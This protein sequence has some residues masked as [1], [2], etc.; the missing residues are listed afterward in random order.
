M[1]L[2]LVVQ[3]VSVRLVPALAVFS[4]IAFVVITLLT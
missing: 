2:R 4:V 3:D 1:E